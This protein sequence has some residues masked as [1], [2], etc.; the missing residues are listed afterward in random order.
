MIR[1]ISS[2]S[3]PGISDESIETDPSEISDDDDV[4]PE[5][6][7]LDLDIANVSPKKVYLD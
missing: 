6:S 1:Q 3:C 4:E 5:P 2:S 7:D